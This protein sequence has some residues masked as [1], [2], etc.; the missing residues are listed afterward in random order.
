M[1]ALLPVVA[2]Q[3][4]HPLIIPVRAWT[5]LD[6]VGG[7]VV[8]TTGCSYP[9]ERLRYF[10]ASAEL[11]YISQFELAAPQ[12]PS[13]DPSAGAGSRETVISTLGGGRPRLIDPG[14]G[15]AVRQLDVLE[16]RTLA[17][18]HTPCPCGHTR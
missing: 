13:G 15:Q 10:F 14:C 5:C 18:S 6:V 12:K 16:A 3:A 9:R 11:A 1:Q 7:L 8:G 17:R 4:P 2:W